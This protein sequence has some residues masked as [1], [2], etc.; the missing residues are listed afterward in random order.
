VLRLKWSK[1]RKASVREAGT[2]PVGGCVER[3]PAPASQSPEV[4]VWQDATERS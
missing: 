3:D 4:P 2:K 1:G